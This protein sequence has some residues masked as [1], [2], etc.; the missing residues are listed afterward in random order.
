MRIRGPGSQRSRGATLK[1]NNSRNLLQKEKKRPPAL[2]GLRRDRGSGIC[3][4]N[5][6]VEVKKSQMVDLNYL[7]MK[8]RKR[9]LIVRR[10]NLGIPFDMYGV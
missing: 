4:I 10:R 9:D 8:P 5:N 3:S 6:I 2:Q 1:T 7:I